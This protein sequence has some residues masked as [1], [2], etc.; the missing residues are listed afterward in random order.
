MYGLPYTECWA[1]DFEFIAEPGAQPSPVCM[2]ARELGSGRLLRLW[3][4]DLDVMP[5]FR[6][7]DD[8]LFVAYFASAEWGCFAALGWP[9]PSRVI[10]LYVEHR[11]E[12]NGL[13]SPMG[14]GLLAA[15]AYHGIA[16]I[17]SDEKHGMRELVRRGGPWSPAEQRAILDYCQSDV[18]CLGPLFERM[19][20]GIRASREGFGQALLR[21]RYTVAV[22]RMEHAGIPI[23]APT[24]ERIR[25]YWEPIKLEL[26][27]TIDK[28]YGVYEST[29]FRAG[30]FAAWLASEGISWPRT[31][32]GRLLLDQDTF[33]DMAK[34]HPHI[35]PLRQL[36]HALGEMRLEDLAVGPDRRNRTLI[37]PFGART[38]RNTPSNTRSVFGPSVWLRGLIRPDPG[39]GIAYIDWSSQEVV[40][41]AALSGDPMLQAAIDTGDPY[42]AFA[43]RAGLAPADASKQTHGEIRS[44]CKTCVLGT[45]Y[46]MG[47][48]SLAFR[49]GLS[50]IEAEDLLRRQ[51][52]VFPVFTEWAQAT[53]DHGFLA[54]RL[55]TVFGWPI[56]VTDTVRP[57]ALR[58]F[59]MQATGAE[60]LRLAC[61]LVTEADIT[62]CAPVH[63]AL[64][65]EADDADL[66][67]AVSETRAYMATA[68]RI[69]LDGPEA[70]TD[71]I[72]VRYPHRYMD[73]RGQLM[74]NRVGELLHKIAH[75]R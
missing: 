4:D 13:P 33:R 20:L 59:P 25:T 39:R 68:S 73:P 61:C 24:L 66:D 50:V 63:D 18:D 49:T 17:T 71:A 44:L 1:L 70:V 30:L 9:M 65:I 46:G 52:R 41:A 42:L 12:T 35:E 8:V 45:N 72:T 54:G 29:H 34:T 74:W 67:Q 48:Q 36:R 6:I 58:N 19:V 40:I 32:T 69:V 3:H 56:H 64:L 11:A 7:A 10:D 75:I 26:I 15:L 37:S 16:A 28:D 60:M 38:G 57:T 51:V 55:S 62:V 21:G 53:I 43:I 2:V 27:G 22:A 23:D 14:R 31:S 5:P 47:A